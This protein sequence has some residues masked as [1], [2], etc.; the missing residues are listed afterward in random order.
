MHPIK[1]AISMRIRIYCKLCF[2]LAFHSCEDKQICTEYISHSMGFVKVDHDSLYRVCM[3]QSPVELDYRKTTISGIGTL[4]GDFDT[5]VISELSKADTKVIRLMKGDFVEEFICA[6]A[7]YLRDD[8][9]VATIILPG[10]DPVHSGKIIVDRRSHGVK[11]LLGNKEL[12]LDPERIKMD[13]L[14]KEITLLNS[15]PP[16]KFTGTDSHAF[17]IQCIIRDG[18]GISVQ[19]TMNHLPL[20]LSELR[21]LVKYL[22]DNRSIG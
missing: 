9:K 16:L 4:I 10:Y 8:W 5:L 2:I 15:L 7:I 17:E 19:S 21:T 22:N 3:G 20:R 14:F 11:I 6:Q 12:L 1:P 18:R 13:N